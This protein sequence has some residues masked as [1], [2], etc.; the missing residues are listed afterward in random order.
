MSVQSI[1]R[2]WISRLERCLRAVSFGTIQVRA[3][4]H[5]GTFYS[6][7]HFIKFQ[8]I[9]PFINPKYRRISH[10]D[11]QTKEEYIVTFNQIKQLPHSLGNRLCI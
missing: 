11:G 2:D 5:P 7:P 4:I 3:W 8:F 10:G 1:I 6:S 9:I